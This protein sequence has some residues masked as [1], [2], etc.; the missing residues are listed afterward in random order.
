MRELAEVMGML[1]WWQDT[2]EELQTTNLTRKWWKRW[3]EK[4]NLRLDLGVAI[5]DD[6]F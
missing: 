1:D 6:M 5:K 2:W 3:I 4:D